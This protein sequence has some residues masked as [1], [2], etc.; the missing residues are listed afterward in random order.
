MGRLF[1]AAAAVLGVRQISHYEGQAAM[2]LEA[3]AGRRVAAERPI[4]IEEDPDSPGNWIIDP[5][6]L[7][8]ALGLRRQRGENVADLAADFHAS[9]A[10]AATQVV[11]RVVDS[12][13]I[14]TV[15]L[16][17]GVFQNGRL[18]SSMIERLED[19]GLRVLVPRALGPN[20]GA[21]SYGQAVIAAARLQS[22]PAA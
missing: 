7:L 18:L 1:D 19:M 12:T 14:T 3:L 16:G 13:G 22:G 11:S 2:E 10:W 15:A 21:I 6:P 4:L 9:V 8:G 20:D 17:G 5:V